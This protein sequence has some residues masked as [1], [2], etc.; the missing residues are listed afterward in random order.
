MKKEN[1]ELKLKLEKLEKQSAAQQSRID[2]M[3]SEMDEIKSLLNNNA[4]SKNG[5]TVELSARQK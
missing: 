1:E 4:S 2:S 3:A 5:E